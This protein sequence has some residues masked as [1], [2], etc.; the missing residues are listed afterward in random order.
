LFYGYWQS[1]TLFTVQTPWA[2]FQ[3]MAIQNLRAIQDDSTRMITDFEITFKMLRFAA[4]AVAGK[5]LYNTDAFQ[6][7]SY[8]QAQSEK[9]IGT[10]TLQEFPQ[11]FSS[12]SGL[13]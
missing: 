4:A 13:G 6:G 12:V 11:S 8:E 7:R 3:D 5:D 2:I 10:S 1:R 9:N